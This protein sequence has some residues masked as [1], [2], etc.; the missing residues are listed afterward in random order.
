MN[1]MVTAN[2]KPTVNSCTGNKDKE[3]NSNITLNKVINLKGRR[4][5]E[6]EERKSE[7]IRSELE[8]DEMKKK[9]I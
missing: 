2:Q 1:F 4:E 3:R 5:G 8:L 7:Q 6:K 9:S